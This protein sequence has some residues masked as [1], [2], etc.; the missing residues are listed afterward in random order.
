M[1]DGLFDGAVYLAGYSL[2]LAL[3]ARICRLLD[4]DY[5]LEG[6]FISFK[7]HSYNTLLRLA[8][9]E[10][11][12]DAQKL[13]DAD[14]NRYWSTLIGSNGAGGTEGWSETW[15]YRSLGTVSEASALSFIQAIEDPKSGI[16]T[17][18]KTQW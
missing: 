8:G 6:P 3:K 2:E 14:F 13:T 12:F 11:A 1:K 9:L 4:S 5:P 17:W 7:T 18:I 16:L 10:K 15:R